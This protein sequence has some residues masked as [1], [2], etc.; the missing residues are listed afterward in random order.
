MKRKLAF[1]ILLLA[2][3]F[4]LGAQTQPKMV[5]AFAEDETVMTLTTTA[6]RTLE[7]ELGMEIPV[8]TTIQTGDSSAELQLVPNGTIIRLNSGTTFVIEDL[9]GLR[10]GTSNNFALLSGRMR[11]VAAKLSGQQQSYSIRTPSAVGGV[12]GTDFAM[13]VGKTL[14]GLATDWICVQEGEVSFTNLT[15]GQSIPIKAGQFADALQPVFQAVNATP[16]RLQEIFNSVPFQRL[17]P[18]EVPGAVPVASTAAPPVTPTNTEQP[19][20]EGAAEEDKPA[21]SDP[22]SDFLANV[23]NMELGAVTIGETTYS[24]AVLQPNIALDGFKLGLYLPIIYTENLFDPNDWYRPAGNYEWSFGTDASFGDR[25]W[26]RV[27]DFSSDLALKIKYL[28]IGKQNYSPWYL[29][30]G[31]LNSMT[32]GLGTLMRNFAN[33]EE[34]PAVRRIGFNAGV[35]FGGFELET[36]FDDLANPQVMGGR[37]AFSPLAED[38]PLFGALEFGVQGIVDVRPAANAEDIGATGDPLFI[39]MGADVILAK[40]DLGVGNAL[41]YADFGTFAPYYRNT[42]ATYANLPVGFA[43]KAFYDNEL[44]NFGWSAGV[45]GNILIVDYRFDFRMSKG[46]YKPQVFQA[47]YN[48]TKVQYL[49]EINTYLNNA[50]AGVPNASDDYYV[51]GI[52]GEASANILDRATLNLSYLWPWY[53]EDG[54]LKYSE[55]DLLSIKFLLKEGTIPM[56]DVHGSISYERTKFAH[57]IMGWLGTDLQLFDAN[58]VVKGEV[59]Y[60]LAET[61]DLVA[62]VST[63]VVTDENGD[64]V[65]LS[66]GVTPQIQPTIT[67]EIRLNF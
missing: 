54:Q 2:S 60:P 30:V 33:D 28:E 35:D 16:E 45:F 22:V 65:Y 13:F 9:Q 31:S 56:L 57:T 51:T 61:L 21:G 1:L 42:T 32:I 12:R 6:G 27:F 34:F 62:L 59:F 14:E 37:I 63:A 18:S 26:E 58:T 55:N 7:A 11:S 5:L 40:F 50:Y 25:W 4:Q 48:R 20:E 41:F 43:S 46:I 3:A 19:G 29:K 17:N 38:T 15:T 36:V 53:V 24:K 10:G 67:I 44:K 66:D 52:Y 47:T 8:G 49:T 23:L 64:V 39:G